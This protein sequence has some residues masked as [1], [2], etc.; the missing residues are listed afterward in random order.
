M[1][2]SSPPEIGD[3]LK[4]RAAEQPDKVLFT[5]LT[6]D[7]RD[8]QRIAYGELYARA[9]RIA[10]ELGARG[11]RQR[12]VLLLYPPGPAFAPAFF[13]ALLA[14]AIAVPAPCPSLE[15]HFHRLDGIAADCTPGAVLSTDDVLA[16]LR[17]RMPAHS[18]LRACPW[19]STDRD[20]AA[21]SVAPQR[22]PPSDIALLQYTSG[23]TADPRGVMVTHGNLAHNAAMIERAFQLPPGARG[24]SWLP[25][26]HDMGLIAGFVAPLSCGGESILMS[27]ESFLRRPLRWL[28]AISHYRGQV[29]GAPN[30]AYD[31]CARRAD[32]GPLPALDLGSWQTAFVGAEPVRVSTMQAF[33]DRFRA[34]GFQPAALTPCYGLAEATVL[35][36]CAPLRGV[37]AFHSLSREALEAGQARPSAGPAAVTLVGCG[38]PA[39][40]TTVRIVDPASGLPLGSRR[41]GEIWLS[42]PQVARGYWGRDDDAFDATLADSPGK[43]FLRTGDLGFLTG[44]GELV[45]V[46]RLKDVIVFNGQKH[47]CH[48]L[49]LTAGTSHEA[50]SPDSCV[51][52]SFDAG[53][54]PHLVVIAELPRHALGQADD[55]ARAIRAAWFTT[56][57]L[58]A[59][60]IAFVARGKLSRTTSGKL[61]RRLSAR[62][63]VA[64]AMGV[65]AVNGEALPGAAS[66]PAGD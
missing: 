64:G 37:P 14:R 47:A 53:D 49:E 34:S 41:V 59:R 42:G 23:S 20:D 1:T 40:G 35:V 50:L 57:G 38:E 60:T 9:C 25:H 62:R 19:L 13:G 52:V 7:G 6:F 33:A 12:P 44:E 46:E 15:G 18:P 4:Q 55:V 26:F 32:R 48:D 22:G 36:S 30:F 54:K 5:H 11:L 63:L 45:F 58:A 61:Q 24:V 8:P 29:C 43:A 28:E 51:V 21:G 10:A 3:L 39:V 17:D 16:R 65:L 27:P 31:L 2:G 66:S 56:H